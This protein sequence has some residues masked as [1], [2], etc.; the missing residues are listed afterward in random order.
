MSLV[1]SCQRTLAK[2]SQL[3]LAL[4]SRHLATESSSSVAAAPEASQAETK[5]IA[6][7]PTKEVTSAEVVSGAPEQLRHRVVRIYQ[8]AR[9]TMQSGSAK[10]NR[11]RLDWDILP[12]GGRWE[13][14]LMGWASS[15]DYMQ[16]TRMSFRSKED[17]VHFAEKQ[18]WDYYVQPPTVKKIPPKNYAENF[19]YKPHKLRIA[20]TK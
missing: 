7:L 11:W 18:G 3:R 19:V 5:E 17:A 8:P 1:R 4:S 20:R 16:G 9:S 10:T 15:A 14:P 13:N 6:P 12:G 2:P